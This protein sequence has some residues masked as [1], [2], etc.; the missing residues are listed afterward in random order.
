MNEKTEGLFLSTYIPLHHVKLPLLTLISL[1]HFM[2]RQILSCDKDVNTH[3]S[4]DI[5]TM[6]NFNLIPAGFANLSSEGDEALKMKFSDILLESVDLL[7][8]AALLRRWPQKQEEESENGEAETDQGQKEEIL[9]L[10][11]Y[12][13][14]A[15]GSGAVRMGGI[16]PVLVAQKSIHG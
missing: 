1:P 8:N 7:L 12:I 5:M 16:F 11:S 4:G 14:E 10:V 15:R 9:R 13:K 2:I 6:L 3:P